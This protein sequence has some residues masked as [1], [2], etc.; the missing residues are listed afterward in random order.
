[1]Q[2]AGNKIKLLGKRC[3]QG[4]LKHQPLG[5]SQ[6]GMIDSMLNDID[7]EFA[8]IDTFQIK[9]QKIEQKIEEKK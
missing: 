6:K 5:A 8:G 4:V 7:M 1:M 9:Q 2:S 3:F